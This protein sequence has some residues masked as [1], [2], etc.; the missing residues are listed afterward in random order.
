VS[1]QSPARTDQAHTQAATAHVN[2]TPHKKPDQLYQT[3][4]TNSKETEKIYSES[5]FK[6]KSKPSPVLF[7]AASRRMTSPKTLSNKMAA[8]LSDMAKIYGVD[9][10]KNPQSPKK[11]PGGP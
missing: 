3:L 8:K 9:P 5:P 2:K 10:L 7:S 11:G 6:N 4:R 1:V